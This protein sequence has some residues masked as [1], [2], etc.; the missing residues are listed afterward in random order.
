MKIR[1]IAFEVHG[2]HDKD[3]EFEDIFNAHTE[4]KLIL[5]N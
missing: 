3:R 2:Y 4:S 5:I 1:Y